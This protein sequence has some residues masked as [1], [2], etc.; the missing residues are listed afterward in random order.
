MISLLV[1]VAA[2]A[3]HSDASCS[4]SGSGGSVG[5]SG[6]GS[7]GGGGGSGGGS[8]PGKLAEVTPTAEV[9]AHLSVIEESVCQTLQCTSTKGLYSLY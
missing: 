8:S 3:S 7:G 1:V 4:G 5:G 6:G 2:V 9:A